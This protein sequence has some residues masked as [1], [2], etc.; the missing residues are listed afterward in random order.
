MKSNLLSRFMNWCFN[1]KIKV[2]V[3]F[4][5]ILLTVIIN[6]CIILLVLFSSNITKLITTTNEYSANELSIFYM[7]NIV[8]W[9]LIF[10]FF[11]IN[12]ILSKNLHGFNWLFYQIYLIIA[13]INT[14]LITQYNNETFLKLMQLANVCIIYLLFLLIHVIVISMR[15]TRRKQK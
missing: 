13:A 12:Y 10:I 8:F 14:F 9:F 15:I 2:I 5:T 1:E 7:I 4:P 6:T 3:E 11:L